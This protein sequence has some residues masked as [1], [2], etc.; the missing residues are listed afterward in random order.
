MEYKTILRL[1]GGVL[2]LFCFPKIMM[3]QSVFRG[4]VT[5]SKHVEIISA[6]VMLRS[7]TTATASLKGYALTDQ[8]GRF[9]FQAPTAKGDWLIVKSLGYADVRIRVDSVRSDYPI[10]MQEDAH[11]LHEVLVKGNYSGMKIVGDTVKFDTNHFRLGTEDNVADVLR[12]LPG[13]EVSDE[14]AVTYQGKGM[15]KLLV[16]G[17]DLIS[18][19]DEGILVNNMNADLMTGAEILTN[20]KDK[21]IASQFTSR[22]VNALNIKTTGQWRVT[23]NAA[24][25]GGIKDKYLGKATMIHVGKKWSFTGLLSG[26][27]VG[28]SILSYN[29]LVKD[30]RGIEFGLG[31]QTYHVSLNSEESEMLYPSSDVFKKQAG[32]VSLS[33]NYKPSDKFHLKSNVMFNDLRQRTQ[34]DVSETY[35]SDSTSVHSLSTSDKEHQFARATVSEVWQPSDNFELNAS[36]QV[37]YLD[38]N[39]QYLDEGDLATSLHSHQGSQAT[40]WRVMQSGAATWKIGNGVLY[41]NVD[42]TYTNQHKRDSLHTDSVYFSSITSQHQE[43]GAYRYLIDSNRKYLQS[44]FCPEVGY[45]LRLGM[46][47]KA[48]WSLSYRYNRQQ[49]DYV[50]ADQSYEEMYLTARRLSAHASL[51]KEK[52]AFLYTLSAELASLGYHSNDPRLSQHRWVVMPKLNLCY[53]FTD[54]VSWSADVS[55]RLED[56]KADNLF[57]LPTLVRYNQMSIG[58]NVTKPYYRKWS[59]MTFFNAMS[60]KAQSFFNLSMGYIINLDMVR[61]YIRQNGLASVYS[62]CNDGRTAM[63]YTSISWQKG[64]LFIPVKA[65]WTFGYNYN[66]NRSRFNDDDNLMK[67]QHLNTSLGL[68][69][70]FKGVLNGELQ[71]GYEYSTMRYS[72]THTSN[73]YSEWNIKG[74]VHL[75]DK[76]WRAT[77]HADYRKG[78]TISRDEQSVNLG[79]NLEYKIKSWGIKLTGENLLHVNH[80]QWVDTSTTPYYASTWI[81]Q[82]MP[83]Y[84]LLGLTY[85][86]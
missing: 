26:N 43:D 73:N 52:G 15:D 71:G 86:F 27:N 29:D 53:R 32:L 37:D 34:R 80:Y 58:T 65:N 79:F 76:S 72:L 62:Y 64:L 40:N 18:S 56:N 74:A 30:V 35:L 20:Y 7:D 33:A 78:H 36:T 21:S 83:G 1:L 59:M 63:Y 82:K 4:Q 38:A 66:Q 50:L 85:K 8:S 68:T 5:D 84:V 19:G 14:G 17:K 81:Y 25:Q 39:K 67:G 55:Y 42:F 41:G 16:D 12:R 28:N 13:V 6:T 10:V 46:L 9:S 47:Y 61:P 60:L 3:A 54:M 24:L 48:D 77:M 31:N 11:T 49:T 51:S 70:S 75:A 23:G 22:K 69:S 2:L 45:S 44:Q 57:A